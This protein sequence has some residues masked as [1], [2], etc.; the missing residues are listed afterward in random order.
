[1]NELK[2]VYD[3]IIKLDKEILFS[4]IKFSNREINFDEFIDTY[5][6]KKNIANDNK[7]IY[8]YKKYNDFIVNLENSQKETLEEIK[9]AYII[10]QNYLKLYVF[11]IELSR[12]LSFLELKGNVSD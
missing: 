11:D 4:E 12:I 8:L 10:N 5:R 2:K 7:D 9:L 6:I 3:K 1:M